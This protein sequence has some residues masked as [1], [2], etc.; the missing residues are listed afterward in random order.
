MA[1]L[2]GTEALKICSVSQSDTIVVELVNVV[3]WFEVKFHGKE[4]GVI[5]TAGLR[6]C[7]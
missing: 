7:L 6:G 5:N 4:M 2:K 3:K 1:V